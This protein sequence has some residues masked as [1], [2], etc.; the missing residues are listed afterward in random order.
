MLR[1]GA[2]GT[3]RARLRPSFGNRGGPLARAP[4]RLGSTQ[5]GPWLTPHPVEVTVQ[6]VR[7]VSAPLW[8]VD[9]RERNDDLPAIEI[10]DLLRRCNADRGIR[11]IT[12]GA[13]CR[14]LG[15]SGGAKQDTPQGDPGRH[16]LEGSPH[17]SASPLPAGWHGPCR[18][19]P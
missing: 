7:I 11:R 10:T 15:D 16:V 19:G 4:V 9:D 17:W 5:D 2:P 6:P 8:I 3:T 14:G 1:S 18:C 12:G 13:R